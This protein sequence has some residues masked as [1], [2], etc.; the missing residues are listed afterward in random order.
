MKFCKGCG[1]ELQS[2]NKNKQGYTPN[3]DFD[4]CQNC[5]RSKNYGEINN[6]LDEIYEINELK[7]I[8]DDNVFLVIDV[9][10]PF[11]T[12]IENINNYI[13]PSKLNI[14]VNK[15]DVLSKSISHE[16]IKNW[17]EEILKLKKIKYQKIILVSSYKKINID[18][19][20]VFIIK[21]FK[22]S[23][24]IGYSNVGKSSLIKSLFR[25]LNK[26]IDNLITNSIG[27]TKRIITLKYKNYLIKDYPGFYLEG[28]Y[29][30]IID[31][32]NLKLINPQKEIKLLNFQLKD[33]QM[34]SLDKYGFFVLK[35]SKYKNG[36]QFTFS[37]RVDLKRSKYKN[38][39]LVNFSKIKIDHSKGNRYDLIISGLGIITFK[40]N[41]QEIEL[42]LPKEVKYN[43][44]KS[45][46][47]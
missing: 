34:V 42:Y 40:S 37:N 7:K 8:K 33:Y 46:Y 35:E 17:I 5:F 38:D 24:F 43:L 41:E 45:L 16:K 22:N 1:L 47:S 28:N 26:D 6:Y 13:Q 3:L 15:I 39:N 36:Y 18:Y 19:L 9:L 30:N 2:E 44:V 27:T 29:Q 4:I 11:Q 23:S 25:A 21:S 32:K 12:L 14:V 31:S 10:N 20:S